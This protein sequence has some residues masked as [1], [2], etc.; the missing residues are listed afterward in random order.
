MGGQI[1]IRD[2]NV[3]YTPDGYCV[4]SKCGRGRRIHT[5]A[6]VSSEAN[7]DIVLLVSRLRVPKKSQRSHTSVLQTPDLDRTGS[8]SHSEL[9]SVRGGRLS[10]PHLRTT[11]PTPFYNTSYQGDTNHG[12]TNPVAWGCKVLL[13]EEGVETPVDFGAASTDTLY[14]TMEEIASSTCRVEIWNLGLQ[15]EGATQGLSRRLSASVAGTVVGYVSWKAMEVHYRTIERKRDFLQ[16]SSPK[17][18]ELW[19]TVCTSRSSA[20]PRLALD[21]SAPLGGWVHVRRCVQRSLGAEKTTYPSACLP[22]CLPTHLPDL[23]V[24]PSFLCLRL[25]TCLRLPVCLDFWI[26]SALFTC[27]FGFSLPFVFSVLYSSQAQARTKPQQLHSDEVPVGEFEFVARVETLSYVLDTRS[28]L[29]SRRTRSALVYLP[30]KRRQRF[31]S[32]ILVEIGRSLQHPENE[33]YAAKVVLGFW[34]LS[35]AFPS[36]SPYPKIDLLVLH[37][38][39]SLSRLQYCIGISA[40]RRHPDVVYT[41]LHHLSRRVF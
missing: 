17:I 25:P 27:I 34:P 29:P 36:T 23:S 31:P 7:R 33:S 10:A 38:V 6:D 19:K 30:R 26:F 24:C 8:L 9:R 3:G 16:E 21:L 12:W 11:R 2:G 32:R 22:A 40:Y 18:E 14:T 15:T 20:T 5:M 4:L 35:P 39:R 13:G 41:Y 1:Y 37:V 28:S